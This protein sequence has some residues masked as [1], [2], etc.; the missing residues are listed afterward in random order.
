MSEILEV[1][2]TGDIL[3]HRRCPRSWSFEKQAQ[4]HPYEQVQ[5]MEGRLLHHAM[6][7][8]SRR[9]RETG[10][11]ARVDE[12]EDQLASYFRVLWARGIKTA[13]A[14]KKDTL[15]RIVANLFPARKMHPTVTALIEGAQHT[16][17]EIRNVRKVLPSD[18]AGKSRVLL[19][20]IVDLVVQQQ[21]ALTY[22]RT[23]AW[24]DR[25]RLEGKV[26]T[27]QKAAKPGDVEIW[28]YKGTRSGS[29][30]IP[31]YVRQVVTYAA[32]YKERMGEPPRR[33]V[34]FFVN[35][36]IRE[37]Q[38]LAVEVDD[39]LLAACVDWT[40][41]QVKRLQQTVVAFESDPLAVE[42]GDL[43]MRANAVGLRV[44]VELRQ[45]CTACGRRFD[46]DEYRAHLA[47]G[48]KGS[49]RRKVHPDLD[50]LDVFKN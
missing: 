3:A 50:R 33:C 48:A 31:D 34:L 10:S 42:G 29:V 17:Y 24:T 11:H 9:Y 12:L 27:K 40:Q 49:G 38:L 37:E 2:Y 20:G 46:C 6:E 26:G 4:F 45:Q 22:D 25:K 19:T 1:S 14:S 39:A 44:P 28:D 32:I 8:L 36:P 30:Y 7:W 41:E 43:R 23:W 35:E 21:N 5:A 15:D 18:F 16:E 13:F 47:K